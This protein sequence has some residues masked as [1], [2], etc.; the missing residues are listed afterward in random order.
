LE[1]GQRGGN[2][3]ILVEDCRVL[4]GVL[5]FEHEAVLDELGLQEGLLVDGAV[6]EALEADV[7]KEVGGVLFA[8]EVLLEGAREI[9]K[10]LLEQ[11]QRVRLAVDL[12]R[13][14]Q[15]AVHQAVVCVVLF[16]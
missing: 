5:E 14:S 8:E 6:E 4:D 3:V 9:T 13:I 16:E 1:V 10:L 15:V 7:P 2:K 11:S 12:H